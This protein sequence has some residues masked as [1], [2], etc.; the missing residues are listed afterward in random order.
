MERP[1]QLAEEHHVLSNVR[2]TEEI[3][4]QSEMSEV[5]KGQRQH[6]ALKQ[7][8]LRLQPEKR[9]EDREHGERNETDRLATADK[10]D[11]QSNIEEQERQKQKELLLAKM[12]AIDEGILDSSEKPLRSGKNV[13]YKRQDSDVQDFGLT[14]GDYKPSF[15]TGSNNAPITSKKLSD[16]RVSQRTDDVL[17]ADQRQLVLEQ[18]SPS[19]YI[20]SVKNRTVASPLD[21]SGFEAKV[22]DHLLPRRARQ[23]LLTM[24]KNAR[25][26]EVNDVSDDVEEVAL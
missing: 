4:E 18:K 2:Q 17:F 22:E 5:Y 1:R 8:E 14:F 10:A 12:R 19:P 21:E 26:S 3:E 25:I 11:R 16:A 13:Q 6:Q 23:P 15:L 7:N 20:A 24:T 9:E